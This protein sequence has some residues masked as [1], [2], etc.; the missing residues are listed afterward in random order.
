MVGGSAHNRQPC[1]IVD[2]TFKS[3]CFERNQSLIVIHGKHDIKT[4]KTTGT[5]KSIS[6]VRTET[7]N[8]VIKHFLYGRSNY[9]LLF[10]TEQTTIS[11]MRINSKYSNAWLGNSKITD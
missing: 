9:F 1:R 8:A 5:K 10:I 3:K 4:A 7:I 11:A 6:R 2:T